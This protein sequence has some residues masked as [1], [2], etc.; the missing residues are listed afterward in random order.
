MADDA[1]FSKLFGKENSAAAMALVQGIPKV[2][3]WTAA[4]SGTNTAVEQSKGYILHQQPRDNVPY[5]GNNACERAF[6]IHAP[7]KDDRLCRA[8]DQRHELGERHERTRHDLRPYTEV[9]AGLTNCK[10]CMPI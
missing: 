4:I 1:L 7:Q 5:R 10:K 3:Q 9:A 6:E 2:E 8:V